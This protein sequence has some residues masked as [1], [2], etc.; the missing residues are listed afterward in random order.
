MALGFSARTAGSD[1]I[2]VNKSNAAA[3]GMSAGHRP[4]L[5]RM[6]VKLGEVSVCRS[7]IAPS[8]LGLFSLYC[9]FLILPSMSF[10]LVLKSGEIHAKVTSKQGLLSCFCLFHRV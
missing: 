3:V 9:L 6:R 8:R 5:C 2:L 1:P 4:C 7:A 10:V